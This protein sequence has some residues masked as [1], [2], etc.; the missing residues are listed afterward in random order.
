MPT[1]AVVAA[2][3]LPRRGVLFAAAGSLAAGSHAGALWNG[4]AYDDVTLILGDARIQSLRGA[5]AIL[6][7]GYWQDPELALYRPLTTLTFALNHAIAGAQ[8][9]IFHLT[10]LLLHAGAVLVLLTLL[11]RLVPPAAALAGAGIFAVHPVHVEAVAN[12]AGRAELLAA[13][14]VLLACTCWT[15]PRRHVGSMDPRTL[16]PPLFLLAL[17]S[18]ESAVV[19]PALLPLLDLVTGEL[20]RGRLA[21][22]SR[23]RLPYAAA[24]AGA[25]VIYLLL[26]GAALETLVPA[27][28][29]PALSVL[30][31]PRHRIL[32]ALQAWPHFARLLFVPVTLLADY[33]PGV[34]RPAT[35]LPGM[36][37]L[38]LALLAATI[39]AALVLLRRGHHLAALAPLWFL[40][41]IAPVSSLLLPIGVLVAER[42]LY[43]PSA[44]LAFAAAAGYGAI[45]SRPQRTARRIASVAAALVILL[46]AARSAARVPEWRSTETIFAAQLRDRPD[47]FRAH[48]VEARRLRQASDTVGALAAYTMALQIWPHGPQLGVEAAAFAVASRDLHLARNLTREIVRARPADLG[49]YR[50][51]AAISI[52]LGDTVTARSALEHALGIAPAD[53]LLR[54]MFAALNG[55]GGP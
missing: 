27:R 5:G 41:A 51:L 29:D 18:K 17:L 22:Y 50:M 19:L 15:M 21:D 30:A 49:A 44:A 55:E 42:T 7:S 11:L 28:L 10:N 37:A 46:G 13:L 36:P 43:L 2:A 33:G 24:L 25:L 1:R 20:R 47:S 12:I 9:W 32:T 48:W 8:P 38:G 23:S 40:V 35:T 3:R 54:E 31:D 34:I 53:P 6:T 26:R 39:A 4:F 16:V 45:T 14:F 52:D